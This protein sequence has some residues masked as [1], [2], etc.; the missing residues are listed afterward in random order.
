M[1]SASLNSLV[2][3][4][5]NVRRVLDQRGPVV[6]LESTIITHGIP[7]PE[8]LATARSLEEVIRAEG[9]TPATIAVLHGK[10]RVGLD[11]AQLEHLASGSGIAKASR[12]DIA[13]L[14]VQQETAGTTVAATML[15]AALVGISVFA[16]GGIGGVHRGAE[17]TFDISADLSE[18]ASTPVAVVCAG[19]KSI[20]DTPKTLEYLETL[21]VPVLGYR[22]NDFPAFFARTSGR[23]VDY[24]FDTPRELAKV[25]AT[26]RALGLRGGILIANP[27]PE[28][29]ALP[30]DAIEAR[31]V[32]A[33][34]DA[35]AAGIS[36][37]DLTPFLL[38]RINELTGGASLKANIALVK[39]N[40]AL[41]ARIAVELSLMS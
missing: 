24:R 16:T 41:A 34:R 6:A 40:A 7:Y 18:M 14:L 33:C 21:G 31:I 25:I 32:E 10:L 30:A 29:D 3:I 19:A 15:A 5:V 9:A 36:R 22:T 4:Q 26:H 17:E 27:I 8:N 13:S 20:L 23:S 12:R 37:K 39:N 28:A 11:S 1:A 38:E 35:E 2:D